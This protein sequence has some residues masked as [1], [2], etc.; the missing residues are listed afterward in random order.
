MGVHDAPRKNERQYGAKCQLH[1][2]RELSF[3]AC[4]RVE[5]VGFLLV[6]EAIDGVELSRH[7]RWIIA[8]EQAYADGDRKTD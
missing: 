2:H 3:S 6:P 8:E 1:A 7:A 4:L 5:A